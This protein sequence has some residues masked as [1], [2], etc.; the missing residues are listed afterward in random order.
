ME[1]S[2]TIPVLA[3]HPYAKYEVTTMFEKCVM[4][5]ASLVKQYGVKENGQN[6]DRLVLVLAY[7]IV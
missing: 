5:P 4:I 6:K 1:Q 3:Y 7:D 2:Y